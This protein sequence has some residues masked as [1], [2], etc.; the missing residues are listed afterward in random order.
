M[1]GQNIVPRGYDM[2]ADTLEPEAVEA[3]LESIREVV[4]TCVAQMPSHQDFIDRN[5]SAFA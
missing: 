1:M 5:C 4:Q 3:K 2:L